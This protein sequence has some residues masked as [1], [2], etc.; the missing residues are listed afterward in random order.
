M[1]TSWSPVQPDRTFTDQTAN[2]QSSS[3]HPRLASGSRLIPRQS[4][5]EESPARHAGR[6]KVGW[7]KAKRCSPS[8][9]MPPN[10]TLE[11]DAYYVRAPQCSA[12]GRYVDSRDRSMERMGNSHQSSWVLG[13][14]AASPAWDSSQS[15]RERDG[16]QEHRVVLRLCEECIWQPKRPHRAVSFRRS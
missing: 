4:L 16:C 15:L 8:G 14:I 5:Q 6:S 7:A 10:T 1:K 2:G 12:L 3:L 11:R 13:G 9:V